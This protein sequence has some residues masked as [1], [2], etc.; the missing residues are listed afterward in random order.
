MDPQRPLVLIVEDEFLVR[1]V[2]VDALVE[3]GFNVFE[4]ENAA[5]ALL[6][7]DGGSRPHLLF[8][9]VH[10]PGAMNGIELAEH[11]FATQPTLK[12]II[13]SA[14]PILRDVG[15]IGARFL[16]KPYGLT[17]LCELANG[18]VRA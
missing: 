13:T 17:E 18:L 1:L 7:L 10:M 5:A 6:L 14:L 9:D 3:Q 2:A 16:P 4:A 12:V 11:V 15:H 8:T